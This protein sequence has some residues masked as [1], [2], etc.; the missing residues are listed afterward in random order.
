M[1]TT[2]TAAV[3]A[4]ITAATVAT[5]TTTT[6]TT[7]LLLL[8]I[9][10]IVD[11]DRRWRTQWNWFHNESSLNRRCNRFESRAGSSSDLGNF[12]VIRS[13]VEKEEN[14]M[15]ESKEKC[16]FFCLTLLTMLFRM[17]ENLPF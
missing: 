9:G 1:E 3:T 16:S 2:V 7:T 17:A 13:E 5:T 6:T 4:T 10:S 8:Y 11:M 12:S 14:Q 15:E